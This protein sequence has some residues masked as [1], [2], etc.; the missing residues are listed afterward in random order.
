MLKNEV[1]L[2]RKRF[3]LIRSERQH[4]HS[5]SS[6]NLMNSSFPPQQSHQHHPLLTPRKTAVTSHTSKNSAVPSLN[7]NSQTATANEFEFESDVPVDHYIEDDH[8]WADE[9][10][11]VMYDP[12]Q[13]A[14]LVYLK[15]AFS[16]FFRAKNPVEMQH[17]GRVI[18]AIL[19]VD[20]EEQGAILEGITKLSPA[21]V[22]T[23]TIDS[24]T[25]QIASIF[26]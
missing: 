18:C 21:V 22:A 1:N 15:Q 3:S 4:F 8:R 20:I 2:M 5:S 13:E 7:T 24:I 17:L 12:E 23:T 9:E 10:D 14:R 11:S 16:G 19:G 25:Q 6:N 26:S